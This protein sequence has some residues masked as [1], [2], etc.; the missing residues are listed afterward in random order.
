MPEH[1][2][3]CFRCHE[4]FDAE[5]GPCTK[6]G[7]P[8]TPPVARPEVIQGLYS[9]KYAIDDLPAL[10]PSMLPPV[11]VR[12]GRPNTQLLVGGGA[13]L[14]VTALVV[15]LLYV[16]GAVGG[17]SATTPP[18]A[19]I[20]SVTSAPTT[21]PLPP[22]VQKTLAIINDPMVSAQVK[23]TSHIEAAASVAGTSPTTMTIKF[24]GEVSGGN[25]WG[26]VQQ[27]SLVQDLRLI[28]GVVYR[29]LP[30]AIKWEK[31]GGMSTYLMVAPL[32]GV[33]KDRDIQFIKQETLDSRDVL[34]FQTTRFWTPNLNRTAMMDMSGYLT[35]PDVEV[36]DLWTA[37]DGT[38]VSAQFSGTRTVGGNSKLIDVEVSYSFAQVG[39]PQVIDVPGPQW[40]PSPTATAQH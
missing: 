10:D 7:A 5:A 11:S 29:R 38:P 3:R 31:L 25:Q 22:A 9:D 28:D 2:V 30:P 8:Y 4:V 12:A 32:L 1:M 17:P 15:G 37:L 19:M 18:Q 34:H 26:L 40:A 23:I 20:V 24:D 33:T 21:A 6:C 35:G 13:A 39:L 14:I 16:V 36:L 27:G